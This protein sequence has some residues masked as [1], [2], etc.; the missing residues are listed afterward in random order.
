[1]LCEIAKPVLVLKLEF[2]QNAV[3]GIG[4]RESIVIDVLTQSTNA[5]IMELKRLWP[6]MENHVASDTSGNFR[7][8]LVAL[9]KAKRQEIVQYDD[10]LASQV[11]HDL[12]KAGENRLGTND[13]KFVETMTT[14][15]PYFLDRVSYHYSVRHGHSLQV[16]IEN[17][18]SGDY[19]DA[20]IACTRPP[21][22]YFAERLHKAMKG[23][24]TDDVGL[25]YAFSIHDKA[26]LQHIAKVYE[27]R[28]H[29]ALARDIEGDTS[30][31]YRK[32]LL[33][34]LN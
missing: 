13:S 5:E 17:E 8:V 10:Q 3:R 32:T 30:G 26:Q 25:I 18:T 2:L 23:L 1:L 14:F 20:L 15:S 7:H 21:D 31:N 34:L 4:T 29:G 22:V 27:A 16:A 33:A 11:A 19:K 24:G 12:Y 28:G 6:E 9:M